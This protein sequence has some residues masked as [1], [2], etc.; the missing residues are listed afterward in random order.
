MAVLLAVTVGGMWLGS[1]VIARHRAQAAADLGALAAAAQLAGGRAVACDRAAALVEH[2]GG[3]VNACTVAGLDVMV[4]VEMAVAV[5]I[6]GSGV[7]RASACAGP[8]DQ[9][10]R[11]VTTPT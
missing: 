3:R 10:R 5:R 7:A 8:A 4:T 6:P 1:A 9:A 2:M 11:S